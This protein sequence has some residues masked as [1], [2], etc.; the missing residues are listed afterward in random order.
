[1]AHGNSGIVAALFRMS[2]N[3]DTKSQHVMLNVARRLINNILQT[4]STKN[5]SQFSNIAEISEDSRIGWCY[6][7]MSVSLGLANY[8][9]A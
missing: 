3:V 7:D 8:S 6:G 9:Y 4:R 2:T 1:M 5:V